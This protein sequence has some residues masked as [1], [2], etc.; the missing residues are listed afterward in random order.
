M[1]KRIKIGDKH[2]GEDESVFIIAEAG[3]NHNG[4]LE[5]AKKL[6]DKAKG[7]G[8][9]AV[10]FQTYK[11]EDVVTEDA[12]MADYQKKNIGKE[13][14][15]YEMIKEKELG[16]DEFEELKE[17]C[18]E[19]NILFL[20]T[21]HTEDAMNF[22]EP[23]VPAYKIGSGDLTNLP[24]LEKV[25]KKGKP[26]ILSTGMATLGEVEEAVQTVRKGGNEDLILLHC[27]TNYPT[28]IKNVNLRAMKT[29]KNS[30]KT[31]VGFSDHT[32]GI[33]APIAAV[34]LGATVIEKHFTLDKEMEGPDHKASLEPDELKDMVESIRN[35]EKGLGHGIK[36]P[37]NNEKEIISSVRKSIITEKK[38]HKGQQIKEDMLEIKRPADGIKPKYLNRVLNAKAKKDLKSGEVLKWSDL[39]C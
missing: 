29:L 3:V 2:L 26:I 4:K 8:V 10:K 20:S 5:L 33:T 28:D 7:A 9:D 22:L 16:Y 24:F 32:M 25:A 6:V 35:L 15:Q 31:K 13:K 18:D 11:T 17:Y 1:S 36:K 30:F 23:L 19:K 39:E 21:P 14:S 12:K 37:T 38:I 34:S 27:V